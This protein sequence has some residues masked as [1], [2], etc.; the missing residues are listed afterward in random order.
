[1]NNEPTKATDT[2][3]FDEWTKKTSLYQHWEEMKGDVERHKWYE[4][5]KAGHDI[6]WEKAMTDWMIRF[7]NQPSQKISRKS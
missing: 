2:H 6:G 7:G 5:E 3:H 1:M 4:S